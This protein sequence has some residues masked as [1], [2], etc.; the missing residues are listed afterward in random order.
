MKY[1]FGPLASRR[2]G[3][4]LGIDLSPDEKSCDFDCIYCELAKAVKTDKI[5]NPPKVDAVI[6]ELKEAMD[7]FDFDIITITANG[8]PTLYPYLDE[9]IDAINAI[10]GDKKL[11]ILSNSS[12]IDKAHIRSSLAKLDIVK[13]S[14]D[15]VNEKTFKKIDRP[16]NTV[17]LTN[18][19]DGLIQYSKECTNE[20]V[21]EVL[22]VKGINDKVEEFALLNEVINKINPARV[23]IST[24][25]RPP[26]YQ[27]EA[28]SYEELHTLA[29]EIKNQTVF[30]ASRKNID[31]KKESFDEDE[32]LKTLS[33]RPFTQVD[34]EDIFDA[35]TKERFDNLV[36]SGRITRVKV[37]NIDFFRTA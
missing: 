34:I 5:A 25:D 19:I 28:L 18:I 22:V 20:L 7:K 8:E 27:V 36:A 17:S 9:L 21:L 6:A 1:I 30:I 11:L 33:K 10:K 26:A 13:L 4:S 35:K 37:G 14:L 3:M 23:D 24:I 31:A 16:I 12:T 15:S 32:I 2:F 29:K